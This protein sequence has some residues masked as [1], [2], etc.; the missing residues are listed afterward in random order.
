MKKDHELIAKVLKYAKQNAYDTRE[1]ET[2]DVITHSISYVLWFSNQ[3]FDRRKFEKV[4]GYCTK[5]PHPDTIAKLPKEIFHS[6]NKSVDIAKLFDK[7]E[8]WPEED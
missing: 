2:L 8:H 5:V 3:D 4:A 7:T 6:E 1:E